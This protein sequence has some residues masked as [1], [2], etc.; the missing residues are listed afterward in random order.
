M[1]RRGALAAAV[2]PPLA[3]ALIPAGLVA[4]LACMLIA[5]TT[6]GIKAGVDVVLA[7]NA[8]PIHDVFDLGLDSSATDMWQAQVYLFGVALALF[9][10]AWPFIRLSTLLFA[11]FMPVAVLPHALRRRI[12]GVL[13]FAGK[14]Q[15]L[16]VFVFIMLAVS[17]RLSLRNPDRLSCLPERFVTADLTVVP[18]YGFYCYLFSVI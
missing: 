3:R 6:L 14:W 16:N 10:G 12:L 9:A 18:Q 11:W 15:L 2:V 5:C 1:P 4:S 7:G 8:V 17:F 13:D